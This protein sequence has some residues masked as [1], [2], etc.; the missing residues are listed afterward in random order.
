MIIEKPKMYPDPRNSAGF[1]PMRH[2][3]Q[4][5]A[6]PSPPFPNLKIK[7]KN[8]DASQKITQMEHRPAEYPPRRK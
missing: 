8:V 6:K 1:I 2:I 3:Y 7:R 4:W 5:D